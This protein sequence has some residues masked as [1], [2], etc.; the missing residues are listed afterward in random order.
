VCFLI[1]NIVAYT[2][3][4]RYSRTSCSRAHIRIAI[5]KTVVT[6]TNVCFNY[7]Y[8]GHRRYSFVA[9]DINELQELRARQRTFHGAYT[10]TALGALGYASMILRLFSPQFHRSEFSPIFHTQTLLI[11][12]FSW[13]PFCCFVSS[14]VRHCVFTVPPFNT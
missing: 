1:A 2:I 14:S 5:G 7:H 6:K 11:F 8:R 13:A 3:G 12:C 10:R 4:F 9:S